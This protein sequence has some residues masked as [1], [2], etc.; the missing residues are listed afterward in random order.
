MDYNSTVI[1]EHTVFSL[2]N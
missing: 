2:F 1:V